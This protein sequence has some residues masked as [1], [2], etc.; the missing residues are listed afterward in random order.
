MSLKC[1]PS[2][3]PEAINNLVKNGGILFNPHANQTQSETSTNFSLTT[4]NFTKV[5]N[6]Y[7]TKD[8]GARLEKTI[9]TEIGKKYKQYDNTTTDERTSEIRMGVGTYVHA[10]NEGIMKD[11]IDRTN[12]LDTD[13]TVSYL[14]NVKWNDVSR[15]MATKLLSIKNDLG[16]KVRGKVLEADRDNLEALFNGAKEVLLQVHNY[17]KYQNQRLKSNGKAQIFIEQ[18]LIDPKRDLGGTADMIALYADNT[19]SVFDFKTKMPH[20]QYVD[21]KGELISSDYM[22]YNDKERFKM[23]LGSIQKILKDQYGVKQ[24]VQSRIVPIQLNM[25]RIYDEAGLPVLDTTIN[26]IYYGKNQSPFLT[27]YAPLPELTGFKDLDAF[28]TDIEKKIKTYEAKKKSDYKNKEYYQQKVTDLQ[29]AKQDILVKHSFNDLTTYVEHLLEKTTPELLA[30]FDIV[31]L[32]ET[33][34]ELQAL[35]LVAGA[36]YEYKK[37]ITANSKNEVIVSNIEATVRA[38]SAAIQERLIDVENELYNKRIVDAVKELTG[39]SITDQSDRFIKFQEEGF[40]GKYFNNLSEFENPIFKAYKKLLEDAQY[41]T[42]ESVK[43]TI[44]DVISIDNKLRVWMKANNKDDKWLASVLIDQNQDSRNADN[45][46]DKLDPEFRQALYD[47]KNHRNAAKLVE[48]YEPRKTWAA[49]FET[50]KVEQLEYYNRQYP[51]G[52]IAQKNYDNWL[53]K[54]DLSLDAK[55]NPVYPNAWVAQSETLRLKKS[56]ADANESKEYKYIKS[57]PELLAYYNM[58]E[59]YNNK[60]RKI[61]NV[62]FRELPSNFLPNIRKSNIDRMLDNGFIKGSKEVFNNLMEELNV[63]EDDMMYGE[64]DPETGS[65]RKTIPRFFINPFK[66]TNGFVD[67]GEK[68][69]DLTKSLILFSK[70]A[71]NYENMNKIE[72]TV[73]AMRDLFVEKG[74]QV[75]KR[76]GKPLTDFVGNELASKIAGKDIEKIFQSYVDLYLYGVSVNPIS[77]SSSGKYEK[78]ILAA[79]Q[80]FTLKSLGL[81]FI[82]ALGGFLAAK[83]QAAIEGYKG[84]IYTGKQYKNAIKYSASERPKFLALSAYFDPMAVHYDFFSIDADSRSLLG[85]P[86]ER[87]PIKKYVNSRLL[88]R[89]YSAGDEYIDE[90]ILA[91]M[92]QNYYLDANNELR[93]MHNDEERELHKNRS[94]WSLFNYDGEHGSLAK[95]TKEEEREVIKKF[96]LAA[97]AAQSKIKGT[98]PEEDKAYWQTQLLG[99]LVMQFKSWM[100]GVL[101]ERFGKTKYNDALMLVQMGRL[102]A[103]NQEL[104]NEDQLGILEYMKSIVLPKMGELAKH[105]V[106]YNGSKNNSRI[107]LAYENWLNNSPQYRGVVSFEEFLDAQQKQMKALILELRIILTFAMLVAMLGSD[108]DDDGKKFYQ[109]MWATRKLVAVFSKVQQEISFAYNPTEF[110]NMVKSPLPMAGVLVDATKIISNTYDEGLD[111]IFGEKTSLPFHKAQK[112]DNTPIA[113]YSSKLIP[114][115]SQVSRLLD[116]FGKE[117]DPLNK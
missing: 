20:K 46:F 87:N 72:G 24:V 17:Q 55:G 113:F 82:P 15:E 96:R 80:Y 23:Q 114:G 7:Q 47:A 48:Y 4:A 39:Y 76:G 70:M 60:F 56:V 68:S 54:N 8:A 116:V 26:Q 94:I 11:L 36:T 111:L 40:C 110:A 97:Q 84:Q 65:M 115:F 62:D 45:L 12:D 13:A 95:L 105:L 108:W 57:V 19:A 85:D 22:T 28:L 50:E 38:M 88:L 6:R 1:F 33:K 63:R 100:P 79:K 51:T 93:R 29:R 27:Q 86:R 64:I 2:D 25:N 10:L 107:K 30:D 106:W 77:E 37:A 74:E 78:L 52:K 34:N 53:A 58:F 104:Y 109:E 3:D 98:I 67:V 16:F 99:Q 103:L 102:T 32:R 42:R 21:E 75:I 117:A 89:P 61:L 73:L 43:E 66:T 49:W 92:A 101:K 112:K 91:G 41:D 69:Y 9:T 59:K 90:V 44:T 81:G 35:T 71:Y 5:D 14:Q 18:I 31:K 83:T